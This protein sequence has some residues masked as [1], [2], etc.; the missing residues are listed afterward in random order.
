M[1]LFRYDAGFRDTAADVLRTA[2]GAARFLRRYCN[3]FAAI[4]VL[5]I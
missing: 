5:L 4:R 1:G 3:Y 2:G